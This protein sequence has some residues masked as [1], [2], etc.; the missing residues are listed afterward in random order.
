MTG[1]RWDHFPPPRGPARALRALLGIVTSIEF[2][3]GIAML[4]LM[5]ACSADPIRIPPW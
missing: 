2:V 5:Y 4:L 3:A 1:D